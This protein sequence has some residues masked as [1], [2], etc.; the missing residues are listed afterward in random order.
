MCTHVYTSFLASAQLDP[1]T[2]WRSR[3]QDDQQ[4]RQ[5]EDARGQRRLIRES[6]VGLRIVSFTHR[7]HSSS[8]SG[9]SYLGSYKVIPK[10]DYYGAYG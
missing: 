4:K 5:E 2:F 7:L 9:D 6:G 1:K 10:R 8:F 3:H